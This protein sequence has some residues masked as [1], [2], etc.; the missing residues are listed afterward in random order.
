MET[1]DEALATAAGQGDRAAFATLVDRHYDRLFRLCWR[2]T[3]SADRA[4][5]LAQDVCLKLPRALRGFRGDARFTTWLHSVA[6][7]AARDAGRRDG[8]R[9]KAMAAYAAEAP[10]A[11]AGGL[12]AGGEDLGDWLTRALT[13]LKPDLAET[14]ALIVGEEM[15]Q[16]EAA[17]ALCV[18]PGTVAWRMSEVKKALRKI[19]EAEDA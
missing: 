3:G 11:T 10:L 5:D 16:A 13:A 12:S 8:T 15:S 7:N 14:A 1:G 17:E 19:A 2:L 18:S 9:K 6:L 4:E